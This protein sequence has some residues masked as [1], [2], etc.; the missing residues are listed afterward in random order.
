[1]SETTI[2]SELND[3]INKYKNSIQTI[4]NTSFEINSVVNLP[5][6]FIM[7]YQKEFKSRAFEFNSQDDSTKLIYTKEI[8]NFYQYLI[9]NIKRLN[10][11]EKYYDLDEHSN[12][13]LTG[14]EGSGKSTCLEVCAARLKA[15]Q[16]KSLPNI[17]ILYIHDIEQF[18]LNTDITSTKTFLKELL[19]T[20]DQDKEFKKK[21]R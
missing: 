1:M 5:K 10:E 21:L 19:L 16:F 12:V 14:Y 9:G 3:E 2:S 17:R 8:D 6:F 15:E 7:P 4:E 13:Y 18:I 11:L 20:F